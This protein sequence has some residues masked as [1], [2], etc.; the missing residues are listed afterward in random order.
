MQIRPRVSEPS[1][2]LGQVPLPEDVRG[3]CRGGAV[4]GW[5]VVWEVPAVSP[6]QR[7]QSVPGGIPS[8][9]QA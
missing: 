6:E 8:S 3:V 9:D 2:A 4:G 5:G 1:L 7:P